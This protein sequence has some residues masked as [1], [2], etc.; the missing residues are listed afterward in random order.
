MVQI[1]L[2]ACAFAAALALDWVSWLRLPRL[3]VPLGL[4]SA[5]SLGAA[6]AWTLAAPGRYHWPAWTPVAGGLLLVAST[7][8]LI[9]SLFLE[10][11]FAATYAK[12]GT[13]NALVSTGTYALVRHPGV[14]WFAL[15]MLGWVLVK[16]SG[17]MIAAAVV[18]VLLDVVL[19]WLEE[20]LFFKRMFPGY[21]E[22]QRRTPM[23]VPTPRSLARCLQTWHR[24]SG[25][26]QR[27]IDGS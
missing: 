17:P 8:L 7:A 18:W 23:L 2:G 14:L 12:Q 22:Y 10:I 21:A 13:G 27:G 19:V 4:I 25:G 5:V 1:L 15:W 9:Y 24:P 16:P 3:K 20:L 6:L 26:S 11:P